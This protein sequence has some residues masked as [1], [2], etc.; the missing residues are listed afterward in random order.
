M[1]FFCIGPEG[2]ITRANKTGINFMIFFIH[3]LASTYIM[4]RHMIFQYGPDLVLI[5]LKIIRF[6]AKIIF[7]FYSDCVYKQKTVCFNNYDI[8][9]F[10]LYLK[11]LYPSFPKRHLKIL[12]KKGTCYK[13]IINGIRDFA[14]HIFAFKDLHILM[15]VTSLLSYNKLIKEYVGFLK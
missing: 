3:S 1:N 14:I 10:K 7:S 4:M 11:S 6:K 12:K 9:P 2:H 8:W 15:S 13:M 5:H